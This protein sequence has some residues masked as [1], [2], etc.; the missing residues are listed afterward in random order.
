MG[1]L[2]LARDRPAPRRATRGAPAIQWPGTQPLPESAIPDR[3]RRE[4]G[5]IPVAWSAAGGG[6]G[7]RA[8]RGHSRSR[9]ALKSALDLRGRD[10]L[11]NASFARIAAQLASARQA[12][13]PFAVLHLLCHGG[14]NGQQSG[15]I[16]DGESAGDGPAWINPGRP[17]SALGA[18]CRIALLVV[19][20]ACE[21]GNTGPLGNQLGSI[22]QVLHRVG[23]PQI[24]ASRFPLSVTG[25]TRFTR[26][27]IP[28]SSMNFAA[29]TRRSW[30]RETRSPSM[31]NRSTGPACSSISHRAL[32][33]TIARSRCDPYRGLLA[34]GPNI[35]ASSSGA[36]ARSADRKRCARAAA[37]AAALG[38]R[39]RLG[40][41][42]VVRGLRGCTRTAARALVATLRRRSMLAAHASR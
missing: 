22:A 4:N 28:S 40:H 17:A 39:W 25:S 11:P 41:W 8:C 37:A 31:R 21:S 26:A 27:F 32:A 29:V 20:C 2:G 5:R 23:I 30:R 14:Q 10:I 42:Q 1:A 35:S 3:A 13:E 7:Q 16:L 19:L 15:L 18:V 33:T 6:A 36:I 34:L 38:R 12:G 9:V 24:I